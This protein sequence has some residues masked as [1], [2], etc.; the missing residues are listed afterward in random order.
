MGKPKRVEL[1]KLDIA[2]DVETGRIVVGVPDE[3]GVIEEK[4]AKD[5]TESFYSL[6]Q[7]IAAIQAASM[8]KKMREQPKI[9]QA[10]D[11]DVNRVVSKKL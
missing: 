7:S 8:Q 3:E 4:A 10:S 6:M 9:I 1:D 5:I 11:A 2:L